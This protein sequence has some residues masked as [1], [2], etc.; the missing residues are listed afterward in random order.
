M[1]CGSSS[2][3]KEPE[4]PDDDDG[5]EKRPPQ[6]SPPPP[7]ILQEIFADLVANIKGVSS[8]TGKAD[9]DGL[10]S[11]INEISIIGRGDP[12]TMPKNEDID[13]VRNSCL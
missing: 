1:G 12:A 9:K 2:K 4:K 6:P 11:L 8:K 10:V 3:V 5:Q 7:Y 13:K